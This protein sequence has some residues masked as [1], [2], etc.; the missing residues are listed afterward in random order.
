MLKKIT[1]FFILLF[2]GFTSCL[3]GSP[4]LLFT[5]DEGIAWFAARC[6]LLSVLL[7]V[8]GCSAFM[9]FVKRKQLAPYFTKLHKYGPLLFLL[10]KRDF[11]AKYKRSVLGVMWSL[12][13]PL[14]TML[15]LTIVF[16]FLFRFE[17]ENFPVY[18]LS[19]Q[20]IFTLFSEITNMGM[21]SV[22]SAAAMM[23]KINVPKYI[24][25]LSKA[26]SCLINFVF[27]LVALFFVML[28]TKAPFHLSMLYIP[29]AVFY[30]FLFST[31]V[32]LILSAA[33]VFFRDINYLY[34]ISLTAVTYLTPLFYPINIVPDHFRWI[35]SLNPLYHL[36]E[37]FRTCAIYGGIPTLWQNT[38]CA[39]VAF[40]SLG[41]GLY[42]FYRKQDNF[43]LYI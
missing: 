42:V 34:S 13:S 31:G 43:I 29:V 6:V 23:K 36:V 4:G 5:L 12:L 10:V 9:L 15:V 18:L 40:F 2:I 21:F 20:I 33:V 22:M 25:P 1:S 38:V 14:L 17:I 3:L 8:F 37:C 27:S 28:V 30:V 39:L 41:V 11:L 35:I 32:G 7:A 16:S 24:F 26:V 19:G